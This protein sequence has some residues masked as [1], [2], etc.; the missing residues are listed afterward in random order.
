[1]HS[2][3]KIFV[4]FL[5]SAAFAAMKFLGGLATNS[6]MMLSDSVHGIGDVISIGL[7][8]LLERKSKKSVD[9][10]HTYGHV[11]YSVLG[12]AITTVLLIIASVAA[13]VGAWH[14]L[15]EPE[16]VDYSGMA[17]V[18]L[19]GVVINLVAVLVTRG[20][21]TLNQRSINLHMLEDMLGWGVVLIG[22]IA[23]K[24]T[25]SGLI[26]P[27]LSIGVAL[28]I[29]Y[30][31]LKN[32]KRI[33]GIYLEKTPPNVDLNKIRRE[34]R[35]I[36]G[37]H[38]VHHIH[39]RSLDGYTNYATLHVVVERYSQKTKQAIKQV[40]AEQDIEHSTIELELQG[41][42]CQDE[43]CKTDLSHHHFHA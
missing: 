5:L 39:V 3:R 37:V 20:K 29:L 14:R 15:F 12:G 19:A 18:A 42:R 9:G 7:S 13:L 30:N 40:L 8:Y 4:A 25:D 32:L 26:D 17:L 35:K 1:M 24:F 28:F 38:G 43:T 10:A 16:E 34:L 31:A 11:R 41:E 21:G 27:I 33:L 2:E 23:I 36:N 22:A 6:M